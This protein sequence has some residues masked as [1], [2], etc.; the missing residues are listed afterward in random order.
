VG[1]GEDDVG[2]GVRELQGAVAGAFELGF[3]VPGGLDDESG[4]EDELDEED[5]GDPDLGGDGE[6]SDEPG[7]NRQ[8][9]SD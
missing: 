5:E 2:G 1:A 9:W 3:A 4:H 6:A 8:E 7:E